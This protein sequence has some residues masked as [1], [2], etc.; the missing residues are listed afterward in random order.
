MTGRWGSILDPAALGELERAL[1]PLCGT[2]VDY[3]ELPA[4]L[5]LEIEPSQVGT[6]VGTLTDLLLPRIALER[7]IGLTKA[8][9]FGD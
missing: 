3:L 9:P 2:P 1:S 8:R 7:E 5:G 4:D 6:I